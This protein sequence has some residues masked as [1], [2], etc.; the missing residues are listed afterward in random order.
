MGHMTLV[1]PFSKNFK[2]V[3]SGLSLGTCTL[4]VKYVALTIFEQ[5]APKDQ[6]LKH[7]NNLATFY[8]YSIE[9]FIIIIINF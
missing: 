4:N 8:K 9:R 3:I 7:I 1:G 2:G 6:T 5:L